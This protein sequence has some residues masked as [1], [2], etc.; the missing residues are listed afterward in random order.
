M[1]IGIKEIRIN[2]N[3]FSGTQKESIDGDI[4]L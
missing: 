2:L 3:K 4:Y 1:L